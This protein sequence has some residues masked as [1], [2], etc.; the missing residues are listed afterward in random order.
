[1]RPKLRWHWFLLAPFSLAATALPALAQWQVDGTPTCAAASNQRYPH[2]VGDAAGGAIVTWTDHRNGT[3]FDIYAQRI[4]GAGV[5]QWSPDGVALCTASGD[6]GIR[7]ASGDQGSPTIVGDGA[8]GAIVTW[9]DSRGGSFTADIYAQHVLASGVVDAVWP[10]DGRALCTAAHDQVTPTIVGDGAGGAI[11]AWEDRR[12]GAEYHIYAQHVLASGAVDPAWPTDGRALCTAA[13]A[14]YAVTIVADRTGGAI[15]TWQ[16]FRSS[17]TGYDIYAQ[18][19]LASGAVDPAWPTDGRALCTAANSQYSPA[20]VVDGAGGAI[21]TWYD[22]RGGIKYDIYAQHVLA[23]GAVDPAWPADGRALCTATG[24]QDFPAIIDDGAG[25][26]IV[27]WEDRRG[28]GDY[29]IYAQ[30]VL[31]SGA[32]DPAWP[33]DGRALCTAANSQYYP[34]I[35]TDGSGGAVV[36]WRDQRDIYTHIYAQHVLASGAVDPAWPVDGR[37]LCTAANSQDYAT[38]LSDGAGGAI[39]AWEDSRTSGTTGI[40]IYVQRVYASSEVAAVPPTTT[41]MHLRLL[42]PYPNPSPGGSIRILF[43]LPSSGRVSAQVLDLA[44]HRVRML[45][46]DREF[47]AGRQALEWD[48]HNDGRARVPAGAYFIRVRVGGHA[49]GRRLVLLD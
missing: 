23:S 31:G 6:Q 44:G 38:A 16:D 37:A 35:V 42:P 21:V 8:G 12:D 18:H 11:V 30:H 1:V 20:I 4:G 24:D 14:Q 28:A 3:N 36:T 9:Y 40:D 17:T 45:A 15:A 32:V 26:A 49:E 13:T 34:A 10:V 25:G 29:H 48:G 7:P 39:V 27:T 5:P 22:Y 41:P 43:D 33:T 47:S 46:V 2:M 19:V